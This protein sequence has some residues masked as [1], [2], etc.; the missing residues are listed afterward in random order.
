MLTDLLKQIRENPDLFRETVKNRRARA[1]V[2][3]ILALD[4]DWRAAVSEVEFLRA[5]QNRLSKNKNF[6]QDELEKAKAVK[7][8]IK[9]L[10]GQ[11]EPLRLELEGQLYLVPNVP[12]ADV[13]VGLDETANKV[14]REVGKN[15]S[16]LLNRKIT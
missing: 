2:D 15:P 9:D 5:E 13:P 3:K 12:M 8:R 1:D 11:E 14:L 7:E 10:E 4:K 6:S 16:F